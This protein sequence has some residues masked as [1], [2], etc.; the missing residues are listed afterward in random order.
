[1]DRDPESHKGDNG[2]I[3]VI[4]G[5]RFIHGAP[6]FNALAAERSGVD[7]IS[8]CVP[9]CHEETAKRWILNAF[10]QPFAGD[11]LTARD[12]GEI[13]EL[14][15]TL[16][17]AVLGSGIAKTGERV[18]ALEDIVASATCPMVLDATALQRGTI[19]LIMGKAVVLTPHLGELERMGYSLD[20]LPAVAEESGA[21]IIVKSF[22]DHIFGADRQ[23]DIEGGN[24]G[25]TVGGTGDAL[26]GL[27]GGLI[28]QRID[29]FDAAVVASQTIKA[30]GDKLQAERGFG[31][32]T[33]DVIEEIPQLL[34]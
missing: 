8:L 11:D 27:I 13:L 18:P 3:A 16:D 5:S 9:R 14:I 30:A 19:D 21:V 2:K 7:T 1:M 15:A 31:Y 29:P 25:L 12:V 24:P 6:I 33:R 22:V 34:P 28:A 32:T 10:V 26:A 4:G 23:E 20:D 17:C